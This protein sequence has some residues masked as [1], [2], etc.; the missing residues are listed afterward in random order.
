MKISTKLQSVALIM[1]GAC[2]LLAC[3]KPNA[4][5]NQVNAA[6]SEKGAA[7]AV[8]APPAN[9]PPRIKA[10]EAKKLVEE[11]KAVLIDVRGTDAYKGTHIKGALDLSIPKLEAGDFKDLP[12]DKRIIAYCTCGAEQTS[13]HAARI[14]AKAGFKEASALLGGMNAWETAGGELVRATPVKK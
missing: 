3:S 1:A 10:E 14:L 4:T 6:A 9:D 13:A 11:G 7:N 5:S 8:Q 12:K 2:L